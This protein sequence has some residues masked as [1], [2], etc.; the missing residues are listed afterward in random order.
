MKIRTKLTIWSSGTILLFLIISLIAWVNVKKL[1]K[2]NEYVFHTSQMI[3]HTLT[4]EKYIERLE[5]NVRNC[6]LL[7]DNKNI[8]KYE[9]DKEQIRYELHTILL[10]VRT[11]SQRQ[12]IEDASVKI[13]KWLFEADKF[14]NGL[15]EKPGN[16][17]NFEIISKMILGDKYLEYIR[18]DVH[19]FHN[20]ESIIM[21]KRRLQE[22]IT[23]NNTF[24]AIAV[25]TLVVLLIFA[26]VSY[27]FSSKIR[28]PISLITKMMRH[29][30]EGRADL[31]KRIDYTKNDEIG[32]MIKWFNAFIKNLHS[33]IDDI[34]NEIGTLDEF[35]HILSLSST[36]QANDSVSNSSAIDHMTSA[37]ED[38]RQVTEVYYNDTTEAL[39][40]N[41][42]SIAD[43]LEKTDTTKNLRQVE[44]IND[45]L[46]AVSDILIDMNSQAADI[47]DFIKSIR[48][49]SIQ[50]R[51]LSVNA[52]VQANKAGEHG[53]GFAVIAGEIKTLS[54][55]SERSIVNAMK[56]YKAVQ[57]LTQQCALTIENIQ[58][59]LVDFIKKAG[60][61]NKDIMEK[62][63]LL[64]D[65]SSSI[66]SLGVS[67]KRQL[68]G[69]RILAEA[70]E[71]IK[72]SSSG[73]ADGARDLESAS[74]KI[75]TLSKK[76]K[77]NTDDFKT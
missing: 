62:T 47:E 40:T 19:N 36:S 57:N 42:K 75:A 64:S 6:T 41:E 27:I 63:E 39:E 38:L 23:V 74:G 22:I 60:V 2:T 31:T 8:K 67:R 45:R 5:I 72:D 32:E 37:M 10:K 66:S 54:A 55:T 1:L 49:V 9:S 73:N 21:E 17:T 43:L 25:S 68:E 14:L 12:I 7:R 65:I 46:K 48:E 15:R 58:T 69:I 13:N 28:K 11:P 4:L 30:A 61:I 53:K 35:S 24:I 18:G 70:M 71:S 51:I 29:I 44:E 56:T 77:N 33:L 20:N 16:T 34:K 50:S 76:L 26:F 59:K 3:Q 52:S